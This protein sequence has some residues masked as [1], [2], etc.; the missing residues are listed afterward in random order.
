MRLAVQPAGRVGEHAHRCRAPARTCSA[1]KITA[2]GSAPVCCALNSDAGALGPDR[3]AARLR[4]RGTYRPRPAAR[5]SPCA[6]SSLRQLADAGGLA[7]AVDA[8]DQHD[9]GARVCDR[10]AAAARRARAAR[11][12]ARA[13]PPAAPRHRRARGA[14]R[15]DSGQPGSHWWPRRRRRRISRRDSRSSSTAASI[16]RPRSRLRRSRAID[17]PPRLRRDLEAGKKPLGLIRV[18]HGSTLSHVA[19][20]RAWLR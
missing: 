4:R 14:P 11:P 19:P 8:D 7:R 16:L 1:S 12:A 5:S 15:G 13:A 18:R 17:A 3:A 2:P 10:S 9:E 20:A 6:R